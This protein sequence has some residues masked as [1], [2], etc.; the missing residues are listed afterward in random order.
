MLVLQQTLCTRV[1]Q[2]WLFLFKMTQ[3]QIEIA[4]LSQKVV[5]LEETMLLSELIVDSATLE[6]T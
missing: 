3:L 2:L 6:L 5:L 1:Q 4:H